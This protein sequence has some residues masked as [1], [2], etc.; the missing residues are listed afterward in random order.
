MKRV[1]LISG[2]GGVG[3]TTVAAATA[4]AAA[5]TGRRTLVMSFDL[6]HSL[7]DSFDLECG[8]FDQNRGLPVQVLDNLDM[9]E[10]DIQE[11]IERQWSEIYQYM[12][13]IFVSAGLDNMVA[14]E[15]AIMPGMDDLVALI[16]VNQHYKEENYDVIVVDCPPTSESLRFVNI[17][18]S[19]DW[20]VRKRFNLDRTLVKLTRPVVNRLTEYQLPEDSYFAQLKIVF[21]QAAGVDELLR[22]PEI[23]TVRLVTNAEKMVVRETQRAYTYFCMYGMTTDHVVINRLMPASEGYFARWAEAHAAYATQ[24]EEYFDP[25]PVSKLPLF[26]DEVVGLARLGKVADV[27]FDGTD[28][29]ARDV[30]RPPYN[31]E[32]IDGRYLLTMKL[33]FVDKKEINLT[34]YDHEVIIRIGTFKRHVALPRFLTQLRNTEAKME[35]NQL[36]VEFTE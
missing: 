29:A 26:A 8:L 4:I 27:L 1:I 28:P 10:I 32:K 14:E 2:K 3:K 25:V 36:N 34:R 13:E 7:S 30:D 16:C 9:Q 20:Y 35:D 21:E 22:D 31:F 6:A 18:T 11:E 19:V 23:T 24:I 17:M 12:A 5:R 15:V 33:P